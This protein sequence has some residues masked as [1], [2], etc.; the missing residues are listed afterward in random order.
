MVNSVP[1]L[2]L[3]LRYPTE[4]RF[5]TYL[6]APEGL[7]LQL[8]ALAAGGGGE[9]AGTALLLQGGQGAG[10]THL[11]V[12]TCAAAGDAGL[13][14]AFLGMKSLRGRLQAA[15]EGLPWTALVVVDDVDA[16]AGER[17]DEIALFHLHN[18]MRDHGSAIL[19][20]AGTSPE[21]LPLVLPDL[22]S[23]LLQC[24]RWSLPALDDVGRSELLRQRAAARGLEVDET[25]LEWLLRHC[26]RDPGSL[27]AIFERLDQAA[28]AAQRRL[29]LPF[30][31]QVLG[32]DQT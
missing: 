19:Y 23:R 20:A 21:A 15:C 11:L 16:I 1:Q 24:T 30:L 22:R 31:R 6:Q 4:Q 9:L 2:P 18:R 26:S 28:M 13:K 3:A 27:T 25:A 10:K 12:A 32:T 14:P 5:D 7:V 17:A 8:Q 29:T